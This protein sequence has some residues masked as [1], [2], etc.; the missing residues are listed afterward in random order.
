MALSQ[1]VLVEI[2]RRNGMVPGRLPQR[3]ESMQ[4]RLRSSLNIPTPRLKLPPREGSLAQ[5]P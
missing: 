5:V 4:R 3:A 1:L 2:P